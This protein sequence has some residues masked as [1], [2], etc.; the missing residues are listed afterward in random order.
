M[1]KLL[2][3]DL[4]YY[5]RGVCFDIHNE[6]RGG[7]SEI[8]YGINYFPPYPNSRHHR[9]CRLRQSP[10]KRCEDS[11][12]GLVRANAIDVANICF[13]PFNGIRVSFNFTLFE[14]TTLAA[15]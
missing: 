10:G 13:L 2:F 7:H 15:G 5:L 4:T 14:A 11:K 8:D 1:T 6:L 3:S 12:M 9:V